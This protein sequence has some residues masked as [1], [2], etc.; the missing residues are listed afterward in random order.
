MAMARSGSV[1]VG[2]VKSMIENLSEVFNEQV[3][4]RGAAIHNNQIRCLQRG[5]DPVEFSAV[6]QIE[7]LRVRVKPLQRR[8][9]VVGINRD[10]GDALVLEELDEVDGEETFADTAFAIEDEVETFH[11]L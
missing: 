5:E 6:V 1:L 7:K 4:G 8:I 11:A 3:R 10:V 9:L 2:P